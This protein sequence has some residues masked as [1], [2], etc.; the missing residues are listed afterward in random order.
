MLFLDFEKPLEE[1]YNQINKLKE[2]SAKNKVDVSNS[3]RELEAAIETTR[4]RI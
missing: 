1:L 2:M 3:I 4:G